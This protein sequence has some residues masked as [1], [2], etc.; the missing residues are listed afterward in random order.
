MRVLRSL[1]IFVDTVSVSNNT[2]LTELVRRIAAG[3]PE[4]EEELVHRYSRG[5]AIIID[6]IVR[7]TSVTEDLRQD[8]FRIVLVKLRRG[9]LR[10]SERLSGF[11]IGV[12]RNIAVDYIRR[13]KHSRNE[14]GISDAEHIPDTAPNQLDEVLRQEHARIVR[15]LINEL[16]QERDRELLFRYYI[17]EDDKDRICNDLGLTRAQFSNVAFRAIRRFKE[18]YER[19]TS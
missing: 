13:A 4:A 5:I 11:V 15:Q 8:T 3:A 18:L 1:G 19:E 10:E 16:K 9:E 12:A 2:E 14:E 17:A 6:Q 7:N